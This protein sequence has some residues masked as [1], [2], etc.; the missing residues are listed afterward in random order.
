MGRY[1][2]PQPANR[3][4]EPGARARHL[5]RFRPGVDPITAPPQPRLALRAGTRI[6]L[7]EQG[8]GDRNLWFPIGP[9]VTI[10]GQATGTPN[11]SGRFRDLQVEPNAGRRVYA[12]SAG[13]GVWFS[14]DGG[15]TWR[16][17]DDWQASARG[18][19]GDIS[20]AL[21]CG[22]IYVDWDRGGAAENGSHDVVWV[23]T[24]EPA[25]AFGRPWARGGGIPGLPSGTISGIGLLTATGP[26][27]GGPWDVQ[28]VEE[29]PTVP[30][31]SSSLRGHG[32]YRIVGDPAKPGRVVA[33]TT[34]GLYLTNG[35]DGWR[36]IPGWLSAPSTIPPGPADRPRPA[37]PQ[38][39]DVVLT[40]PS[41]SEL[42]VWVVST[43]ELWVAE[44]TGVA[45]TAVDP[46]SLAFHRVNLAGVVGDYVAGT[47]LVLAATS[48]GATVYVLGTRSAVAA[49]HRTAPLAQLWSVDAGAT[50]IPTTTASITGLPPDLFGAQAD[51]DMCIAVHPVHHD[52]VYVGGSFVSAGS[53][54]DAGIFRCTISGTTA[55][56]LPIGRGVHA[57]DHVFR[58]GPVGP[59]GS[60]RIVWVGCD[61]GLFRSTADG[62][63][64]TF[65]A[66]NNGLAVLQPGYVASHPTNPGI[67]AAG[68]QDNGTQV[69][70]GDSVWEEK[71]QGDG[72][73]IVYD[74]A[75]GSGYLRQYIQADWRATGGTAPVLRIG[76]ITNPDGSQTYGPTEKPENDVA[77]FY[78]GADATRFG[79]LTHLAFGTNRVWYSSNGGV[80][81][82]TLP[83]ASDPRGGTSV[84]LTRDVLDPDATPL[85]DGGTSSPT[86][87]TLTPVQRGILAVK[88]AH[89][90]EPAP[91]GSKLRVLALLQ[92]GLVWLEGV[93]SGTAI[94][95]TP[96]PT[97]TPPPTQRFRGPNGSAETTAFQSGAPLPFLP[98]RGLVSDVAV[99]D[100]AAGALGSCYVT[101]IG[102]TDLAA[103]RRDTLYFFDGDGHWVP[104][105]VRVTT[106]QGTWDPPASRVTAPALG[107]V[108]DPA[109]PAQVYVATS[110]GVLWGTL[111]IT[112]TGGA[113][114][115]HWTW[116]QFM[117]GLPE[118]AVQDLSI[119]GYG[120][121]GQVRLLRAALQSRGVWET[122]LANVVSSPLTYLRVYPSDTRRLL[123]TPPSGDPLT[124]GEPAPVRW[125][126]SPDITLDE[127]GAPSTPTEADLLRITRAQLTGAHARV[128]LTGRSPVVQVLVHHRW[129]AAGAAA[130]VRVALLRHP[131][132]DG[133]PV[134]LEGVWEA[135]VAA[136]GSTV[137]PA[138]LPGSWRRAGARLWQPLGADVDARTPRAVGFPLDLT[139][140]AAGSTFVLLAVVLSGSNQIN[141]ADAFVTA[142]SAPATTVEQ[143]VFNTPHAAAKSVELGIP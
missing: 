85:T 2:W 91:A 45:A 141:A 65:A 62:D 90:P 50:A 40:R 18:S 74:P 68:F 72:G 48:D 12:A 138:S 128:R 83:S 20:N 21:S 113:K 95:W 124:D 131:M 11:V 59:D 129:W 132:T 115:Y 126:D 22:A 25:L 114:T 98:A 61:G 36:R 107:V 14:G 125:D 87:I 19:V 104:C 93:R 31:W 119:R 99:H 117:N 1:D 123:P 81:W 136:A 67:V 78:S 135:L 23:G 76:L 122:D 43:S 105:G 10:N 58:I 34:N 51:Y 69:R 47:R 110:V 7:A 89:V 66:R 44:S 37:N 42:R 57:D 127:S 96:M 88:F 86:E 56:P 4:D 55:A 71:E 82:V 77:L 17:L 54:Y 140:D 24:G 70:V 101:T 32:T 118:A 134:P 137:A 53:T 103:S 120:S 133:T 139:A 80:S 143:L 26:A 28:A 9:S 116:R 102:D 39:L 100:P 29:S 79:G 41:P 63:Q 46:A 94:A 73:G 8:T 13:G 97:G 49:D 84:D 33:A 111:V 112:N 130:D 16:P 75:G 92:G 60:R 15:D 6:I 5:T 106:P 52:W 121:T 38:P 109:D 30:G 108:V 27:T 3:R 64:G 142:S 35:T